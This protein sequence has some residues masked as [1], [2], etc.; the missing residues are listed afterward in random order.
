MNNNL[1]KRIFLCGFMGAGKSTI[2]KELGKRLEEPFIDL[3]HEIEKCSGKSIPDIFEEKGEDGFRTV[4]RQVLLKVAQNSTGIVALGGGSLQD[5][6]LT[7]HI[8]QR[9]LL[10]FI[11]APLNVIV[12]RISGD[13]NRPL[14][15]TE[16]G[17]RK[18]R[19]KLYNELKELYKN[20]LPTYEQADIKITSH[21]GH[22]S[23]I[24][25]EQLLNK[26]NKYVA[27]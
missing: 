17:K 15:L 22:S 11:E 3:D 21:S 5:M 4:E 18:S 2:G 13:N 26:I 19:K 14:L 16:R 1:P 8:K 7:S 24:L 12:D 25:V 10:I 6:H 9:G 27:H 23:E 20:R